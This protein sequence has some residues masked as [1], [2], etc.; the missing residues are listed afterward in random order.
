MGVRDWLDLVHLRCTEKLIPIQG[1]YTDEQLYGAVNL[2]INWKD[3]V[4]SFPNFLEFSF[5][6]NIEPT[7][8]KQVFGLRARIEVMS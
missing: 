2:Q 4:E 6:M 8:S 3:T 7:I 5:A 1:L